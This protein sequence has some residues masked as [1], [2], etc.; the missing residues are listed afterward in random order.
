M[1][2]LDAGRPTVPPRA[3]MQGLD[4]DPQD[5]YLSE[6]M[7]LAPWARGAELAAD[8]P[9]AGEKIPRPEYP[10]PQFMRRAWLCLNG[11]WQFEIDGDDSGALRGLKDAEL[12]REIVVP[13]CP[14]S[15][16]SGV[17]ETGFMDAVWYR[18]T[19]RIP[20]EWVGKRL[21][22]H[23]QAVDYDATVWVDGKEVIRHRGGWTPFT[24]DLGHVQSRG[25][26]RTI[27]VRARDLR[28]TNQPRGKQS[29]RLENYGVVYT[30]T[31]GIW[32]TVWLEPVPDTYMLRPRITPNISTGE[33][34]VEFGLRGPRRDLSIRAHLSDGTKELSAA[35][36]AADLD[37][38]PRL[39]IP[40]ESRD[41]RTWRPDDPFL[42]QLSF[43]LIDHDGN[44][45]DAL[46]SYAGLRSLVISGKAVLLN[47]EPLF[48]R[49]VLDQGYYPD[50]VLTAPSDEALVRDIELSRAAG[51]N[52]ARLHQKV[53]EER[54]LFHCDRLGYIV[55][56]EFGDWAGHADL[57]DQ[58][59][60]RQFTAAWVSQ[61]LEV[62]ERD[63]SHP[64][65]VGWCPLNETS[66]TL[67][68]GITGLD[69]M[70]RAMFL[71]AKAIDQTRPVLD[72]SGFAHRVPESDI[73]DSHDY[74]QDAMRFAAS[75][76]GL[77]EGRPPTDLDLE[78]LANTIDVE[79]WARVLPGVDFDGDPKTRFEALSKIFPATPWSI[80][81]GG[82]PYFC[83]EF[84]GIWWDS[85][86]ASDQSSWGYGVR[87]AS[88]DEFYSRFE[89]L[90]VT[91]LAN[92]EMFG[93]CYTQLTDVHQEKNGIYRFD[94]SA[95][96]A[97]DRIKS[98]Q[99]RPAAIEKQ[100]DGGASQ[101]P[102]DPT[103]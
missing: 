41:R 69:D 20:D 57:V 103:C 72:A 8:Q 96:F 51:F 85:N 90:V 6:P 27:V 88:I 61:W 53:F 66:Q 14:E 91:L 68:D 82:Q 25:E 47:G 76:A 92:P 12:S 5:D 86:S 98:A 17:G 38:S 64:S 28:F 1:V 24:A 3:C 21:L 87:P 101:V 97:I 58:H 80:P 59:P 18:R 75:M 46:Q 73:Y 74:E 31:T 95:K 60:D 35:N 22:I 63:Y 10:R 11:R 56:G 81:Y 16:L 89:G 33:F 62:V 9:A 100:F 71:A 78:V 49:L 52:G 55:W 93:Y 30:R 94:R 23:F 29:D 15:Q 19:A 4:H 2:R 26:E 83:S 99:S 34:H 77:A 36:S 32:Q 65:I 50:G 48:Q 67:T 39:A 45:V 70:T 79:T 37:F 40:I 42:Y 13:F 7:E 43:E 102:R 84:G 54:F 44:V